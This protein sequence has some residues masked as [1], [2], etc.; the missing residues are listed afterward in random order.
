MR[1]S[2]EKIALYFNEYVC[3]FL[4]LEAVSA[5]ISPDVTVTSMRFLHAGQ[6]NVIVAFSGY[7]KRE[8]PKQ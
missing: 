5:T 6:E 3:F 8:C 2:E 7:W 4:S 1:I